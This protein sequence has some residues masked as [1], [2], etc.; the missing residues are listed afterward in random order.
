MIFCRIFAIGGYPSTAGR[1]LLMKYYWLQS[2]TLV[3]TLFNL[4][5]KKWNCRTRACLRT[6]HKV[7]QPFQGLV[8]HLWPPKKRPSMTKKSTQKLPLDWKAIGQRLPSHH[9]GADA[10]TGLTFSVVTNP[11]QHV[12]ASN[13]GKALHHCRH[14]DVTSELSKHVDS[15][16]ISRRFTSHDWCTILKFLHGTS[17]RLRSLE[18]LGF[19]GDAGCQPSR[20]LL[21]PN[22]R[23]N[24]SHTPYG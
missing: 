19:P 14:G 18:P 24:P 17:S 12:T 11:L 2:A 1:W 13:A 6:K 15:R 20:C 7:Q 4:C 22:A 10:A 23:V 8:L 21:A 5:S 3:Q 16:R 9:K